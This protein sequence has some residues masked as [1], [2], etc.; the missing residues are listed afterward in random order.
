MGFKDFFGFLKSGNA[1]SPTMTVDYLSKIE[2]PDIRNLVSDFFDKSVLQLVPASELSKFVETINRDVRNGVFAP[3]IKEDP[4]THKK[5]VVIDAFNTM[6]ENQLNSESHQMFLG[7]IKNYFGKSAYETLKQRKNLN[8]FNVSEIHVL[9]QEIFDNLGPAFVNRILNNDLT[10]ESL[11]IVKDV[12]VNPEQMKDFKYYY[13]FY[14]KYIGDS[15]VDFES[16]IK[17][18]VAHRDLVKELRLNKEKLTEPEINA[19]IEIFKSRTNEKNVRGVKGVKNFYKMKDN[20]Y[21]V[22]KAKAEVMNARDN[23]KATKELASAIL[24]N[25]FG[26]SVIESDSDRFY[27]SQRDPGTIQKFYDIYDM[28]NNPKML[29]GI[30]SE[31]ETEMLKLLFD[32]T[33]KSKGYKFDSLLEIAKQCEAKGNYECSRLSANLL[34]RVPKVFERDMLSTVTK[35]D[36][37]A[38]RIARGENG[39]S[40]DKNPITTY[41]QAISSPVYRF[42]GADFT[43]LSS[44]IYKEGL[45]YIKVGDNFAESWF[46]FENGTSHVSCSYANQD[47]MCNLEFNDTLFHIGEDRVTYLFDD[48]DIF[49]MSQGDIYT[50]HEE[51]LSDVY[52]KYD[53]NFMSASKLAE[54]TDSDRYN[55][56]GISRY[57]YNGEIMQGGKIIPSA[58]LCNGEIT[59]F[60]AKVAEQFTEYCISHGLKPEGWKMPIVVVNKERYKEIQEQKARG[61]ITK[62]SEYFVHEEPREKIVEVAEQ[63]AEVSRQ[64]QEA[65]EK[66]VASG[67]R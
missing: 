33:T 8:V 6:T 12:L 57:N 42:D 64:E 17:G 31:E 56:I 34:A 52:S 11:V 60:Q 18:W 5:K 4:Y 51:R 22:A 3:S 66:Q 32:I 45:S 53:P 54:R 47:N 27:I 39:I 35:V 10:P 13:D 26:V 30:F 19:I 9:H 50:P 20:K 14:N 58:I 61:L 40:I 55:E 41:G 15:Q 37:M 38:Q 23:F 67:G 28:M 29:E 48:A 25:F 49:V 65:V 1:T 2:N 63:A 36:D 62:N 46:E 44:T 7:I 24:E 16:M 43:F 59:P 21:K